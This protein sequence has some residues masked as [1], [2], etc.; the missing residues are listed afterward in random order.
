[1][2]KLKKYKSSNPKIDWCMIRFISNLEV[3]LDKDIHILA[4]CCGHG[5]YR[6]S[7]VV[8]YDTCYGKSDIYDL[9]SGCL[10]PRK[11]KFYKRDSQG[12]YYIPEAIPL[13]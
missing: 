5:K 9:V 6:M 10:I 12:Y 2:C 4:C 7:I 11:K 8:Q 1:M 13:Q 3:S